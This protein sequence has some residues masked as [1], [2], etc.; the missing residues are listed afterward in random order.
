ME[1]KPG[2]KPRITKEL[3]DYLD[4]LYPCEVAH[5]KDSLQEVYFKAGR[6]DVARHIR[7]LYEKQ[8]AAADVQHP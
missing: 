7:G 6:A 8:E 3:S 5:P 2:A 4:K 1:Y